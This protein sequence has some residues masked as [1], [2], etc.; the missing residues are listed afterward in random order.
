MPCAV[1]WRPPPLTGGGRPKLEATG[2]GCLELT[3]A[4]SS[5]PEVGEGEHRTADGRMSLLMW[6]H[7]AAA[8]RCE[9]ATAARRVPPSSPWGGR[10]EL[11]ATGS[12]HTKLAVAVPR[13][14]KGAAVFV[15]CGGG[16]CWRDGTAVVPPWG[17]EG[18]WE[19]RRAE[20]G[21][22]RAALPWSSLSPWERERDEGDEKEVRMSGVRER[23]RRGRGGDRIGTTQLGSVCRVVF[24]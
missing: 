19:G 3:V 8:V 10:P 23:E 11:T 9:E 21:G 12:G 2:S 5:H 13:L 18:G 6:G 20:G 14:E 15:S 24:F 16:Y 17:R 1:R 22:W 4:T 7:A